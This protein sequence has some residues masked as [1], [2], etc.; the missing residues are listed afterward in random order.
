MSPFKICLTAPLLHRRRCVLWPRR[1]SQLASQSAH[2]MPT[3]IRRRGVRKREQ[4][5][6]RDWCGRWDFEPTRR[7]HRGILSPLRLPVPPRPRPCFIT[8]FWLAA[9]IVFQ[10]RSLAFFMILP[11]AYFSGTVSLRGGSH[12]VCRAGCSLP[13][14]LGI[15]AHEGGH[16]L[17]PGVRWRRLPRAEFDQLDLIAVRISLLRS[18][19]LHSDASTW[20][21]IKCMAKAGAETC[22]TL[23]SRQMTKI[24][25]FSSEAGIV[26]TPPNFRFCPT[27]M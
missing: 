3:H 11:R 25:F 4:V 13:S 6:A 27:R 14:C 1:L 20:L 21:P 12:L 8:L 23:L 16:D 24:S 17:S 18:G 22:R 19:S 2:E 5:P 7:C 10:A 15:C 9:T 26:C